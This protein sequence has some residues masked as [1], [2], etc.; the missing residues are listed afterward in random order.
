MFGSR[1]L[2]IPDQN[3]HGEPS[4]KGATPSGLSNFLGNPYIG[5]MLTKGAEGAITAESAPP[6]GAELSSVSHL[7]IEA[8]HALAALL[9]NIKSA[10]APSSILLFGSRA[11]GDNRADSDWDLLVL[12]PEEAP[13]RLL[14]PY[15][16][17]EVKQ[18]TGVKADIVCEYEAEFLDSQNV[19]NTLA[20]EIKTHAVRIG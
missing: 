1:K 11:R 2:P 15:L 16:A 18:G 4:A 3:S 10:Y 14:D 7:Q 20:Y 9:S 5:G 17:W 19:A 8:G 12:L 6:P 13:R